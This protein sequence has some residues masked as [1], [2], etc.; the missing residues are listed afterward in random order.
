[1]SEPLKVGVAGIGNVGAGV[2]KLLQVHS[3]LL[4]QRCGRH[5]NVTAIS[6]RDRAR[7]RGVDVSAYRWHDDANALAA[8]PEV[9]V[10]VELIGGSDGVAREV[11]ESA[12]RASKPVVTANKALLAHHGTD[13]A[14]LAE[15]NGVALAY[16]A[17]VAGGIPIV[18]ALR[19]GLAGNRIDRVYGILNGTC[20]YILTAMEESAREFD[21]VLGE[22]Q[23]LGYA[24]ADPSFDVD[25][26]D[27]AHKLALLTSLAFGRPV[28]FDSVFIEGIRHVSAMDI[29]YARELGISHQAA[30]HRARDRAWHRTAGASMHGVAEHAHR[31]RS[32]RIQ[33]G[34]RGGRFRG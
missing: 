31:A 34:G 10:V 13:L 9:D 11:V 16:E 23:S 26:V 5:L 30:G 2:V 8:D 18:K 33:R 14:R 24:E 28:D 17:A 15:E 1:M 12:L 7:D 29:G 22:A 25:G 6:A 4:A 27:A 20:N 19:E 32:R 3:A 21:D